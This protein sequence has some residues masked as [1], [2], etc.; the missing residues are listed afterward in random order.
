M[1][2]DRFIERILETENLTDELEDSDAN[3]LLDWGVAWL[4]D[5]LEGITDTEAAGDQVN[6]LM[7]VMRKIN[8]IAG[9]DTAK[10]S[11]RWVEDLTALNDLCNKA[12][13]WADGEAH[14]VWAG[15]LQGSAARL[16]QLSPRETLEFLASSAGG[17]KK[18]Q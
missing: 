5:V 17:R 10:S 14:A 13:G 3:W 11:Q 7:A 9:S 18:T 4:D 16:P 1:D 12:F 2:K 6:A 15:D 8:V